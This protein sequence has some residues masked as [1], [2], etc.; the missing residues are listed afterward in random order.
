VGRI[1]PGIP[2]FSHRT[3]EVDV[4]SEE[5]RE[6]MAVFDP[7]GRCLGY[8]ETPTGE[9]FFLTRESKIPLVK[10]R[11][12]VEAEISVASVDARGVH[13][14]H[15]R[16]ELLARQMRPREAQSSRQVSP[17]EDVSSVHRGDE[18]TRPLDP[19]DLRAQRREV[20]GR[21]DVSPMRPS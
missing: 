11:I 13:L 15:D 8:V 12:V 18:D 16:D 1:T 20:E 9:Y 2:T 3:E 5:I 17:G 19:D 10:E 4:S 7:P 21:A 14:R 6:G